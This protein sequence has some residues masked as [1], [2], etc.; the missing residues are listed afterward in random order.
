MEPPSEFITKRV[1]DNN[2]KEDVLHF[3]GELKA[4]IASDQRAGIKEDLEQ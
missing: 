4:I 3:L 2:D 1:S